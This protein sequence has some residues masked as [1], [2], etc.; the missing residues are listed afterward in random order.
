MQ[1][2]LS[3]RL[4][5]FFELRDFLAQHQHTDVQ[6]MLLKY[7]SHPFIREAALQIQARQKAQTK[8][9]SWAA[10]PAICYPSLLSLEQCSSEI[11]A[12]FKASLTE[13]EILIDLTGGMGVDTAAFCQRFN[14]VI[15]IEQNPELK[16][17]TQHNLRQSGIANVDFVAARSE[18]WLHDYP[19]KANWIYLDPARRDQAGGKVVRLEDCEPAVLSLKSLLFTKAGHILLKASPMLDINLAISDL[20]HVEKVYIIAVENEVK[21][22]I[23]HLTPTSRTDPEIVSVNLVKPP[24]PDQAFRFH[25]SQENSTSVEFSL[26]RQFLYEP[27]AAVLKAGAFRSVAAAFEVFKLHPNSHLYTSEI[28]KTDF[29]G[30]IF[31]VKAIHKL[32]KKELR[33]HLPDGKANIA[34]RNFPMTV[35]QI[36]QQTG[37]REG[38]NVYLFATTDQTN[39]KIVVICERTV[40]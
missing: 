5:V 17:I 31:T 12:R 33:K 16:D 39:R 8:L 9:P 38:G 7:S 15:Y 3:D 30:R 34:I 35:A 40:L 28:L 2:D 27:N 29:P 11:T 24:L 25:R 23:F 6:A 14:Q 18:E 20:Q 32:D 10:N 19:G 21:E 36:R 13:G 26:P 37:I 1:V 4:T 22:L